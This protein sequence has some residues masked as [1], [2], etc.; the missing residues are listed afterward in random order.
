MLEENMQRND[1]TIW[2][3]AN[4]FQMMLDLGET[5]ESIAEKT[6]FVPAAYL[7]WPITVIYSPG[8]PS[9]GITVKFWRT[10][11][12]LMDSTNS[13]KSPKF[14]LGFSGCGLICAASI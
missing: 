13:D 12:F 8:S 11:F 2:E 6:G 5:E 7:L 14:F 9:T 4:G 3:Q 1:L 10:P